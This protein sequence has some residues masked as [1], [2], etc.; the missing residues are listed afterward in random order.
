MGHYS[1]MT[2][3]AIHPQGVPYL[4]TAM[5]ALLVTLH[6]RYDFRTNRAL[7]CCGLA[8]NPASKNPFVIEIVVN[9]AVHG[10][11]MVFNTI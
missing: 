6:V 9:L 1:S 7:Y 11:S 2:N 4:L 8:N 3:S 10:L 5:K